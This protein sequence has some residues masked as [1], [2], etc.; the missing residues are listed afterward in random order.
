MVNFGGIVFFSFLAKLLAVLLWIRGIVSGDF[1]DI[2][3]YFKVQF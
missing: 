1:E 2:F 3:Y